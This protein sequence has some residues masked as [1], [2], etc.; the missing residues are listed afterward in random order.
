RLRARAARPRPSPRHRARLVLWRVRP[1]PASRR[2][3]TVRASWPFSP[4]LQRVRRHDVA[5][6]DDVEPEILFGVAS[7][8]PDVHVGHGILEEGD[9]DAPVGYG[10]GER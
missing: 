3:A 10:A 8:G 1:Q 9:P 6:L 2:S 5:E 4:L 7:G